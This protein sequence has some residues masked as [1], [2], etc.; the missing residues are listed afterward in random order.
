M[1]NLVG[2]WKI[3]SCDEKKSKR[4]VLR[5]MVEIGKINSGTCSLSLEL[6]VVVEDH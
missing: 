6:R 4:R 5:D 3:E 2:Q 1:V